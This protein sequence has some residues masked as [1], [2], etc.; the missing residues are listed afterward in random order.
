MNKK[1]VAIKECKVKCITNQLP[2]PISKILSDNDL[3][4]DEMYT[5]TEILWDDYGEHTCRL[6]EFPDKEFHLRCFETREI[7]YETTISNCL[8]KME[9][10]KKN[11]FGL[12]MS[13]RNSDKITLVSQ[14]PEVITVE[15]WNK[16]YSL[17]YMV[18]N[19]DDSIKLV[20][21]NPDRS[22]KGLQCIDHNFIPKSVVEFAI[23]NNLKL[24][25]ISYIAICKNFKEDQCGYG[26]EIDIKYLPSSHDLFKVLK[27][28]KGICDTYNLDYRYDTITCNMYTSD[29]LFTKLIRL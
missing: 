24:D 11:Q 16:W 20:T 28:G 6:E 26:E 1:S 14:E 9:A 21:I 3:K 13:D 15:D 17:Y 12:Y 18:K 22:Y 25:I 23:S 2:P 10:A 27:N 19:K 8:I 7:M 29:R 4:V 5:L